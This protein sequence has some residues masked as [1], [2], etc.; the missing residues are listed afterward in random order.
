[1]RKK[2]RRYGRLVNFYSY[3]SDKQEAK[4]YNYFLS[5]TF[6]FGIIEGVKG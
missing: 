3:C 5:S 4:E 1:M 6:P 2:Y